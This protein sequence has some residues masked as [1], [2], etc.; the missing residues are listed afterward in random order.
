[1]SEEIVKKNK[2]LEEVLQEKSFVYV[3]DIDRATRIA[4]DILSLRSS[5]EK[6]AQCSNQ[7]L[8]DCVKD[9][10][11]LGLTIDK[12]QYCWLVPFKNKATLQIGYKGYINKVKQNFPDAQFDIGL[13][14]EGDDL[15]VSS[16]SI[17][18]ATYSLKKKNPFQNDVEELQGVYCFIKAGGRGYFEA[19]GKT[20]LELIKS[21][22]QTEK[23]NKK[24]KNNDVSVWDEWYGEMAKKSVIKRAC[25]LHFAQQ[26]SD[27]EEYDN[28]QYDLTPKTQGLEELNNIK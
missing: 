11:A 25:K 20:E 24:Y 3:K 16:D 28:K 4:S 9:A 22:N 15:C 12:N 23:N 8:V 1:M 5:N 19:I 26:I 13:V 14:H 21:K 10:L 6:I 27:L 7:S 17:S 2:S 18:G